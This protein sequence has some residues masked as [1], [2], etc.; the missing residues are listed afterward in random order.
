GHEIVHVSERHLESEIRGKKN[1]SWAMEE[2]KSKTNNQ[3]PDFLRNRADALLRDM[4]NTRLSRDKE[5][6]ADERGT[7]MAAQAGYAAGG[8]LSFLRTLAQVNSKP[9]NQRAFGQLLSTHPPFDSRIAHLTPIVD[10]SAKSGK[11]L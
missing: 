8:L 5:D 7:L 11:T 1:S 4:F 3:T 6:G 9:E 2:A 10:R